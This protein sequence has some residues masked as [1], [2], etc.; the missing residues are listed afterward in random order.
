MMIIFSHSYQEIYTENLLGATQ[1]DA[2]VLRGDPSGETY[3]PR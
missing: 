3:E 2:Y 1:S